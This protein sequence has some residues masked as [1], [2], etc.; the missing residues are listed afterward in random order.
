MDV[1]ERLGALRAAVFDGPGVT[2]RDV[3]RAAGAGRA[4][5]VWGGYVVAVREASFRITEAD[6]GALRAG[7]VG[8]EEIFEVTVAAA[9][10][11]AVERLEAGLRVVAGS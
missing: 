9:V 2:G 6:V 5:G 1:D 4:A 3:R 11:A 7:G 8:E 10:G